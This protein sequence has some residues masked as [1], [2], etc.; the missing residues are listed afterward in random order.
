VLLLAGC[1]QEPRPA[2]AFELGPVVTSALAQE[3]DLVDP[4]SDAGDAD[5]ALEAVLGPLLSGDEDLAALALE[6][7]RA[8]APAALER[9]AARLI[10]LDEPVETRVALADVLGSS[11][12]PRAL[13][14]LLAALSG[15]PEAAVRTQCAWRLGQAQDE[16]VVPELLLRLKYERDSRTA[17]WVADALARFGHLAGLEALVVIWGREEGELREHAAAKLRALADEHG[18]ASIDE[19][20]ERWR[21]GR[22][23][24]RPTVGAALQRE[25]WRWIARLAEWQLRG[26]DDARY[27]LVALEDWIVPALAAALHDE[28]VHVRLHAA[29]CLERRGPR[30]AA[31]AAE[32]EA[33]LAEPRIAATAAAALA[34]LG[35]T[36]AVPALERA[37]AISRDPELRVAAVRALGH[38]GLSRSI[39][40]LEALLEE[41]QPFDLRQALAQALLALDPRHEAVAEV[42]VSLTDERGDAGDAE[43]ALEA[44]L[45][46]RARAETRFAELLARWTAL[47]PAPETVP[48]ASEVTERRQRRARLLRDSDALASRR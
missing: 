13:E 38:L 16:R 25:G 15:A 17:Y 12:T 10:A 2:P 45:V 28:D 43:L 5:E 35:A 26:V 11:A 9:A 21:M 31:A 32:L 27:V 42:L 30:A 20:R 39:S 8:L 48:T 29:Q 36:S 6:D 18:C 19:L 44:W 7:A 37:V 40:V 14:A 24:P 46:E 34:A 22:V 47:G 4:S 1:G 33:A 23:S 41:E 3:E